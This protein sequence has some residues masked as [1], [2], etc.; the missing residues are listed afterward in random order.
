MG[1]M[2]IVFAFFF[3]IVLTLF[4]INAIGPYE[5]MT[6]SPTG[7]VIYEYEPEIVGEEIDYSLVNEAFQSNEATTYAAEC[8][9][10]AYIIGGNVTKYACNLYFEDEVEVKKI[11]PTGSM[12][13]NLVSGGYVLVKE[14]RNVSDLA[15]GDIAIISD[16]TGKDIAHRIIEISYDN[17]GQYVV[18]QGDNNYVQDG[19]RFRLEDIEAKVVGILY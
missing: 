3:G 10:H 18:T 9:P 11:S 14:I 2:E 17:L 6:N 15:V 13:P 12:W 1:K 16:S 19:Q 8:K 4:V 5:A 7:A